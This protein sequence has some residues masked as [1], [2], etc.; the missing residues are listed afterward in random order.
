MSSQVV[1]A[2]ARYFALALDLETM[3][4]FLLRHEIK[5][6]PMRTQYPEVDILSSSVTLEF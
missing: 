6:P 2:I 5:F 1:A 4:C 3:F